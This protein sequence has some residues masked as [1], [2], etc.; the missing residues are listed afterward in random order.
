MVLGSAYMLIFSLNILH[1]KEIFCILVYM[2]FMQ[3]GWAN[4]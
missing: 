4:L 2:L 3:F 1:D